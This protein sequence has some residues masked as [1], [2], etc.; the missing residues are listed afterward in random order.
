MVCDICKEKEK[1]NVKSL[2]FCDNCFNHMA[3]VG[4]FRDK[5]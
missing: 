1:H 5:V 3:D 2:K 4:V